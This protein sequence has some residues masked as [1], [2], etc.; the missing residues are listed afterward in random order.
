M[1]FIL[2]QIK[3]KVIDS[4]QKIKVRSKDNAQ[5]RHNKGNS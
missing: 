2:N 1:K 4:W 5:N 3:K